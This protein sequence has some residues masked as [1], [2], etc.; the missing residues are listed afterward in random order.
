[1]SPQST[2]LRRQMTTL[3]ADCSQNHGSLS[4]G[5]ARQTFMI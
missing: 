2:A 5:P 3:T 1:M 4:A